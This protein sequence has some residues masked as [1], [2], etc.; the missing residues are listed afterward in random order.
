MYG[1]SGYDVGIKGY[2]IYAEVGVHSMFRNA[3]RTFTNAECTFPTAECRFTIAEHKTNT[4][5]CWIYIP[6]IDFSICSYRQV[7][8]ALSTCR[9]EHI[10]RWIGMM[11]WFQSMKVWEP[12]VAGR[13][14]KQSSVNNNTYLSDKQKN[15]CGDGSAAMDVSVAS[16]RQYWRFAWSAR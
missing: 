15:H 11:F 3:E 14:E 7:D 16:G 2:S 10:E 4:Y 6:I 8:I 9:Y 13:R 5:S 12:T 1:D